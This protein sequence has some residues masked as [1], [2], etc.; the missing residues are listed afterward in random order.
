MDAPAPT[1]LPLASANASLA[2]AGGKGQSMALLAGTGLP[3]PT[4]FL[5]STYKEFVEANELQQSISSFVADVA[6]Q[7]AVSARRASASNQR[8]FEGGALPPK[9]AGQ[10]YA[11]LGEREPAVAVRSSA[12]AEDIRLVLRRA[13]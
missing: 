10:G 8:L 4:G 9:M 12:T 5:L 2:V 13:T 1:V 6:P 11:A 3:V 7:Q